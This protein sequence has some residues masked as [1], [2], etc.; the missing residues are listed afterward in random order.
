VGQVVT[1]AREFLLG[2]NNGA[3]RYIPLFEGLFDDNFRDHH[4]HV[5]D[6][7]LEDSL[8]RFALRLHLELGL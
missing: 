1:R 3:N 7:F 5:T 8:V 6:D 2:Q 4:G